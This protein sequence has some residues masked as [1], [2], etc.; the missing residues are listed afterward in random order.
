MVRRM[1]MLGDAEPLDLTGDAWE[2]EAHVDRPAAVPSVL[3]P[4]ALAVRR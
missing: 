3:T 4:E 1:D 2:Q